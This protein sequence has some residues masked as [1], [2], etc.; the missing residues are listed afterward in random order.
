MFQT[1]PLTKWS[2]NDLF[3]EKKKANVLVKSNSTFLEQLYYSG[4]GE[5]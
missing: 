1:L 4:L 3:R 2:W 5:V